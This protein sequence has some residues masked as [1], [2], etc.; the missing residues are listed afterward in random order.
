MSG[1]S[2]Q[3]AEARKSDFARLAR[4]SV[5]LISALQDESGAYPASPTFSAYRGYCWFR[6]G[7]FIADGMSSAGE[8][9]SASRFFDWC[10][11]ILKERSDS[12]RQIVDRAEA[13]DPVPDKQMLPT[14]FTLSG[15]DGDDDWWDFQL[16][17]YGTWLWAVAEHSKRHGL[18][19]ERWR[20]GIELTV[21]YLA[22][23]WD[24]PCF[25]WWEENPDQV[26]VSTL[27]CIAAGMSA[28]A[29][30]GIL[31]VELSE[32]ASSTSQRATSRILS[33]GIVNG[34]LA[35]WLG[36][37][38]VDASLISIMSPM[39][40][41]SPSSEIGHSTI[42]EVNSQLNV[43][44]GVHRYLADTYFGGGQ[45]PLLSCFLGLAF[46]DA[47]ETNKALDQLNWATGT[48]DSNGTMPEQ[49]PSHLLDPSRKQ[50]WV[51]RWGTAANPLLWSHAMYVRLAVELG[52]I[53]G[54]Q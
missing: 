24:R 30:S 14:R 36:S 48:A 27:G 38:Q 1:T 21:Q 43:E 44:G 31:S 54:K 12:V 25:D 5:R 26:H 9:D 16:D 28:A 11:A 23:S 17:G 40:V 3:T 10:S 13:G 37:D 7:S 49:V 33:E 53:E 32:L 20:S 39:G 4:S 47:H 2:D 51:E 50:E 34:H 19:L 29:D 46:A 52:I 22:S 15:A 18:S 8:V 35:K 6:D 45:W 42:S 41:V